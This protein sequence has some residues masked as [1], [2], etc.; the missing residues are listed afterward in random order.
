LKL[1]EEEEQNCLCK[2]TKRQRIL[3]LE[4]VRG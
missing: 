4:N 3:K 1:E 2:E